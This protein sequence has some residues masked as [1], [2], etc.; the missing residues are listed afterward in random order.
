[1]WVAHT[2]PALG[3]AVAAETP[4][5]S[6]LIHTSA[7]H[8]HHAFP[9]GV[10]AAEVVQ[11][12]SLG[13]ASKALEHCQGAEKPKLAVIEEPGVAGLSS[14]AVLASLLVAAGQMPVA[15]VQMMATNFHDCSVIP[16]AS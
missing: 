2:D 14:A 6:F 10:I 7:V 16:R 8:G 13:Q 12:T 4:C 5:S 3:V 15:G 11:K 9:C 1:M